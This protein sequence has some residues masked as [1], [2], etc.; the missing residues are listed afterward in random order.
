LEWLPDALG[1]DVVGIAVSR[2]RLRRDES[3][4]AAGTPVTLRTAGVFANLGTDRL[5]VLGNLSLIDTDGN[6]VAPL[7]FRRHVAGYLQVESEAHS[8]LTLFARQELMT[9]EGDS[10]YF[11]ILDPTPTR[12]AVAGARQQFGLRNA[13]SLELARSRQRSGDKLQEI[14]V[15]WSAAFP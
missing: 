11:A 12:R 8:G 7:R 4:I 2:T 9:H 1:E 14:R 13:V 5:R 15:Q 6:A 10:A 3:L